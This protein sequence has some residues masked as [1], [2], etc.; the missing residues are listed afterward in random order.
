MSG[1]AA[2]WLYRLGRILGG[3]IVGATLYRGGWPC[4]VYL[5]FIAV[6]IAIVITFTKSPNDEP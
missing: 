6:G 3:C 4:A 2:R 5:I 1:T